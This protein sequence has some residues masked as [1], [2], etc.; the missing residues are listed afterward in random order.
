MKK[1]ALVIVFISLASFPVGCQQKQL[2][3]EYK[4]PDLFEQMTPASQNEI[5]LAESVS[6]KR[7]AYRNEL[8]KIKSYYEQ[9]GNQLK[10]DWVNRELKYLRATPRYHYIIEAEVAGSELRAKDIIPKADALYKQALDRYNSQCIFPMPGA[11][12]LT[13]KILVSRRRLIT[14]LNQF[15][16]LIRDYPT[17]DKIDDAAFYAG[18]IHEFFND[19]SIASLYYKRAFQWD[20]ATRHPARYYA[21]RILDEKLAQRDEALMLYREALDREDIY[22]NSIEIAVAE[23]RIKELTKGDEPNSLKIE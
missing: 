8:E 22:M 7:L 6:E 4:S 21:A 3:D 5:A 2:Y 14:A 11:Q 1:T 9:S 10:I 20:P 12:L 17:S 18:R 16:E 19:W 23:A 15:N 13:G